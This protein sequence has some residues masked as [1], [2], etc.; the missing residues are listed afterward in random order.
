MMD[1]DAVIKILTKEWNREPVREDEMTINDFVE[2]SKPKTVSREV[3]R[4]EL[5]GIVDAGLLVVREAKM[6]GVAGTCNAY[7]LAEGKSWEDVLQYIK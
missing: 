5:E 2:F 6:V 3:I 7:S 4:K 1:K